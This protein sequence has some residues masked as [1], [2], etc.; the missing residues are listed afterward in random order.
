MKLSR[1]RNQCVQSNLESKSA[2]HLQ[3]S[4]PPHPLPLSATPTPFH[5]T[6][7]YMMHACACV[8]TC[9]RSRLVCFVAFFLCVH[10]LHYLLFHVE[11]LPKGNV[12]FSTPLRRTC[13]RKYTH[14]A[15]HAHNRTNESMADRTRICPTLCSRTR[16]GCSRACVHACALVCVRVCT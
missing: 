2:L 14:T 5:L 7:R 10:S 16:G 4:N 3:I 1:K 6:V 15:S 12:Q 11:P 8:C 13:A 9:V